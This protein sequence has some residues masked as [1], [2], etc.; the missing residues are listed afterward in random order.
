MKKV[1]AARYCAVPRLFTL[2]VLFAVNGLNAPRCLAAQESGGELWR[3]MQTGIEYHDNEEYGKAIECYEK[4]LKLAPNMPGIYYE[5]AFS[6]LYNENPQAALEYAQKGIDLAVAQNT[7][8]ELP[9]LYDLKGSALDELGRREEAVRVFLEALD[10]YDS[11]NT[12]LY[13]NLALTYY[14]MGDRDK[15][16]DALARSLLGDT[17]HQSGNF[18][19]GKICYE[20]GRRTQSL[21]SLCYFL[22]L[23]PNSPRSGEANEIIWQLVA[24]SGGGEEI[25][26][27]NSGGFTGADLILGLML[28]SQ[29]AVPNESAG[30]L[31][32]KRLGLFFK[33]MKD[34]AAALSGKSNNENAAPADSLWWEFYIPFF[35]RLSESKHF[36]TFC[37]YITISS[38]E[39]SGAWLAANGEK[40]DAMFE[41]L[42]KND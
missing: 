29:S 20:Q 35:T 28:A 3:L 38:S 7:K 33:M 15:A 17:F 31:L 24:E 16:R 4:A 32:T 37:H 36:E 41:W 10:R 9:G 40:I 39:E 6:H 11:A 2:F 1:N 27:S 42:N 23:E 34:Q 26:F 19:L 12:R 22:L 13:Y 8:E 21:Y 25:S 5:L 14:R 30:V 18:L